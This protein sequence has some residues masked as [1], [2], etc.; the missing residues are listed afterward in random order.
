M[1]SKNTFC[2]LVW[3]YIFP[4]PALCGMEEVFHQQTEENQKPVQ[5]LP[6]E[7]WHCI[8]E[9]LPEGQR[10]CFSKVCRLFNAIFW[11]KVRCLTI[12][13]KGPRPALKAFSLNISK[14]VKI[15]KFFKMKKDADF[16]FY[17]ICHLKKTKITEIC[18]DFYDVCNQERFIKKLSQF[19][20][21]RGLH[22]SRITNFNKQTTKA[23]LAQFTQLHL[24]SLHLPGST[25]M[26]I[27]AK[28][29]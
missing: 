18:F 10:V 1:V 2:L 17:L 4:F 5:K 28:N 11:E 27:Q 26:L 24:T 13:P 14:H 29:E 21:L 20:N 8:Y 19:A 22:F 16:L 23:L 12:T 3:F 15:L 7:M 25:Q 9:N 6:I